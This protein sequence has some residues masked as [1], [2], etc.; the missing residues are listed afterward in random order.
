MT[1]F[2][3]GLIVGKFCPLHKGHQ[4]LIETALAACERLI[5][6]SY[7]KPDY[8]R[9]EAQARRHWLAALYPETTRLVADDTWLAKFGQTDSYAI[10]PHDEADKLTHR[11]FTSWLFHNVLGES[12]DAIFT[13]EDYG[14]GFVRVAAEYQSAP[15]QHVCVDKSRLV[16]PISGTMIRENPSDFRDYMSDIVFAS[17]M[18]RAV[19]LGGEST[20]KTTLTK[21]L[22]ARLETQFAAEYGRELWNKKD[23]VLVFEDMEIIAQTQVMRENSLSKLAKDWLFCD[24]SP[25]TTAFYSQSMFGTVSPKLEQLSERDYDTTFLC[26]PDFDFVQDGTRQGEGFRQAQHEWYLDALRKREIP[27]TLLR[28]SLDNRIQTVLKTLKSH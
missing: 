28:G 21:A 13:S 23:G 20:G 27:F 5:L 22:A 12:I 26:V 10:V 17:F 2:K 16:V 4:Y 24:T 1:R 19:F 18:K 7:A 25:L 11:R 3:T 9:C 8:P 14:D 6:I 15:V